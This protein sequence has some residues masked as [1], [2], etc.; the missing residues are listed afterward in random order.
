M[1]L[2]CILWVLHNMRMKTFL[3][4]ASLLKNLHGIRIFRTWDFYVRS[5]RSDHPPC[6]SGKGTS[7]HQLSYHVLFGSW[8]CRCHGWQNSCNCIISPDPVQQSTAWQGQKAI[9]MLIVLAKWGGI[10]PDKAQKTIQ[11][12]TQ[13]GCSA[14]NCQ[15]SEQM[16]EIFAIATW[17][18]MCFLTL[19]LPVVSRKGNR[20]AQVYATDL[21]WDRAFQMASRSDA[22]ET[23][24]LLFMRYS[25]QPDHTCNNAREIIQGKF[26][27]KLKNAECQFIWLEPYTPWW[28]DVER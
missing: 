1:I 21:E 5:L 23:L 22:H 13:V 7:I 12:T 15:D 6:H 25:V 2:I 4:F 11:A 20:C 9:I 27:Q 8:C 26:H 19:C 14:L 16:T 17:H 10:T 24:S 3:R 28:N 18:M